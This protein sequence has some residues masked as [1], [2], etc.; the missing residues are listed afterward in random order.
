MS[1][2]AI[3]SL[4]LAMFVLVASPGPGVFSTIATSVNSGLRSSLAL[5]SGIVIGDLI[6]LMFA[7]SGLSIVAHILGE[8]IIIVKICGGLY[9][10]WLGL[11]IWLS[12]YPVSGSDNLI[13]PQSDSGHIMTGLLITLSNPKVILF[14]CGF[15]P[16][17]IDISNLTFSDIILIVSVV[18]S[19]LSSVLIFYA[20][21][22]GYTHQLFSGKAAGKRIN[23][24][25][26][27]L[28]IIAGLVV[29]TR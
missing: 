28:M 27:V 7:V 16:T 18:V 13:K 9:I 24:F 2:I 23:R 11:K 25:A 12:P 26:G 4:A 10:L 29:A 20:I 5:I 1:L 19:V 3:L 22:A 6:Y 14:Y 15:L 8:Y 17:F 21:L